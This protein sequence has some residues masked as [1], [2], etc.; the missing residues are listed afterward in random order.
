MVLNPGPYGC[1]ASTL[2]HN[3]GHYKDTLH[4]KYHLCKSKVT[5]LRCLQIMPQRLQLDWPQFLYVNFTRNAYLFISLSVMAHY[6]RCFNQDPFFTAR[7][8]IKQ[9]S[10]RSLCPCK[11]TVRI[12][13]LSV[14]DP[15]GGEGGGFTL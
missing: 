11:D 7:I 6:I 10:R 8:S 3:Y 13:S 9:G 12:E 15:G 2:P 1:K 5:K 4:L 14:N